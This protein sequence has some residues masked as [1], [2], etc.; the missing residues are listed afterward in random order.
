MISNK[1]NSNSF[2]KELADLNIQKF[3]LNQSF[4]NNQ[5]SI[6][7]HKLTSVSP[8]SSTRDLNPYL[9]NSITS[10]R[11]LCLPKIR[12]SKNFDKVT[13]NPDL[14][15]SQVDQQS[16]KTP[17]VTSYRKLNRSR[18]YQQHLANS[19]KDHYLSALQSYSKDKL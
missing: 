8:L 16:L 4:T 10:S 18:C 15:S 14:P 1:F 3:S 9:T 7:D 5:K 12:K 11:V 17:L 2:M 13:L 19:R 6:K